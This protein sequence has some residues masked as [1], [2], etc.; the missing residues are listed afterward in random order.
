MEAEE[1]ANKGQSYQPPFNPV[2]NNANASGQGQMPPQAA[3]TANPPASTPPTPP[4]GSMQGAQ[5]NGQ[6]SG[7]PVPVTVATGQTQQSASDEQ[8]RQ[9]ELDKQRKTREE[10]I[11]QIHKG[12]REQVEELLKGGDG[13]NAGLRGAGTY[14]SVSYLPSP[15][16]AATTTTANAAGAT[17]GA[18]TKSEVQPSAAKKKV[19]FKAGKSGFATLDTEVDTDDTADVFATMFGGPYDGATLIGKIEQAPRN[20]RLRF[21]TLSPKETDR[22]SLTINAVAIR[23]E[24]AKQGIADVI[25]NHTLER[26]TSLFAGSVLSGFGKAASQPQGSVIVLPNGQTVAQQADLTGKRIAM[27]ALGEVGSNAAEEVKKNFA[28][29]PTY[30]R[31]KRNIGII[32]VSDVVEP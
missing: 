11:S 26:Y 12:V 2:V 29:P 30:K 19:I 17:S 5:A 15:K 14:S 20:I 22:P 23:E 3:G 9:T 27:F 8:K 16:A 10:H 6:G 32:F 1:A 13:N 25:D 28:Q 24:D 18:A 31:I 7:Q 21:T 4:A